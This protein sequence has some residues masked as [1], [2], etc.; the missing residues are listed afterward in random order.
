MA[1]LHLLAG[2]AEPFSWKLEVAHF[3][4]RLRGRA[5]LADERLVRKTAAR[6]GLPCCVESADVRA[7][8][9]REALSLEMAA[10]RLRHE[11]FVR[12]AVQAGSRTVAL[13]HHA[14]D[15]VELF[16]LRVLRG[17]GG[18]GVGGM[19]WHGP[20][21]VSPQLQLIRPLLGCTRAE[22]MQFLKAQKIPFRLDASNLSREHLRNRIR[23][24]LLPLLLQ[25]QPGLGRTVPRLMEILGAE[26]EYVEL[27][28]RQWLAASGEDFGRLHPALQRRLM[29]I[30]LLKL[31]VALDFDLVER[32]RA[33]P[34]R[35][36]SAAA[37]QTLVR[38][39]EG[40]VELADRVRVRGFE[41][42]DLVVEIGQGEAEFGG[43]RF[44]WQVLPVARKRIVPAGEWFDAGLLG[45]QITLRH[46]RP[47]DRYHPIG[48]TGSVKLQD[49]FVNAKVPQ[50]ERR[51]R[52]VA[53]AADDRIFWVEGLRIADGF[54][55]TK[56][57]Q[58]AL[59]WQWEPLPS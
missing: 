26:A 43:R 19:R 57:T 38:T 40:Q 20:S 11:F 23:H 36:V 15:Q 52:V 30:Q 50:A 18:Q 31:G 9:R 45:L 28:A 46:W 34:G 32:L 27:Q 49:A 37:G 16:F 22:I 47:G 24:E 6:L 5:S 44:R 25:Y 41:A 55:L 56:E 13:A 59:H 7:F 48:A 42:A 21:P 33:A 1:L 4:H 58:C 39:A 29:E 8:A 3:N 51:K 10:R 35:R 2:W 14:D 17:A 53:T 12:A 54:K